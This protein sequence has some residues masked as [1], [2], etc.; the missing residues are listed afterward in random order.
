[1][2]HKQIEPV[3]NAGTWVLSRCG[4]C[5]SRNHGSNGKF[6][7]IITGAIELVEEPATNLIMSLCC[8]VVFGI[9]FINNASQKVKDSA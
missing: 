6:H 3:N 9:S 5:S 1:M 2:V 4:H 8:R 7:D